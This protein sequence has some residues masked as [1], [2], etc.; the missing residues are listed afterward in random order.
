MFGSEILE[1]AIGL[2]FIFLLLSLVATA[3]REAIESVL[4]SRAS[5]LHRGV[6]ELLGGND[7]LTA[8]LY[9]HPLLHGLYL[10]DYA[11]PRFWR[12]P[13]KKKL[14][15]YIPAPNFALALLDLAARPAAEGTP[16]DESSTPPLSLDSV[17]ESIQRLPDSKVRRAVLIA[18]DRADGDFAR[19]QANVEAWFNGSMDRVSGWYKRRTQ[20]ILFG[21]G[22]LVA[23]AT[24][25]DTIAVAR[26]LYQ[27]DTARSVVAVRAELFAAALNR[28][29][30]LPDSVSDSLRTRLTSE[31][32]SLKAIGLPIGWGKDAPPASNSAPG[33]QATPGTGAPAAVA[34]VAAGTTPTD[35]P[36]TTPVVVGR[37]TRP[38]PVAA[39]A[40]PS[41]WS[42]FAAA[43]PDSIVGW[44]LTALA[45][46]L[47]APFW[48]DVL[49]KVM[50][51][52]STVK[53]YEKSPPEGSEDRQ[54]KGGANPP[55]LGGLPA[56]SV[57]QGSIAGSI[58][59]GALPAGR[60]SV[61]REWA[62]GDPREGVL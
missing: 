39:D 60:E 16:A 18:V 24:N 31:L 51:I 28:D 8:A 58:P 29:G 49:N 30:G 26:Y 6:R 44:L 45:V 12:W 61:E 19:A 50:V 62:H 47:G 7:E 15:S 1:V 52:R 41:F 3:V 13:W 4:K 25:V 48:F 22:L 5:D 14:P 27:N 2:F 21:I 40:T 17:R 55:H 11:P 59:S 10:D 38:V 23:I 36:Q 34:L 20:Y 53:P 9:R 46:S 57:A 56:G 43:F 37:T 32:D 33:Q 35:T 42:A 54:P